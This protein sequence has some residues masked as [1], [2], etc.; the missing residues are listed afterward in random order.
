MDNK[1]H[2]FAEEARPK[3]DGS[4][5]PSAANICHP[6]RSDSWPWTGLDIHH[7]GLTNWLLH[8]WCLIRVGRGCILL[9]PW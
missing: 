8:L 1:H 4:D 7:L 3:I 5:V 6:I 9:L 2:G